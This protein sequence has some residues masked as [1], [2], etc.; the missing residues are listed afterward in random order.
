MKKIYLLALT[1]VL[2]L[3]S[4]HNFLKETPEDFLSAETD[5]VDANFVEAQ[6]QGAFKSMLWYRNDRAGLIGITGTDEAQGKTV[7]VN[8]WAEQGAL[9]KYNTTLNSDNWLTKWL[10]DTGYFGINR[11]NN[12]INSSRKQI[13]GV[14]DQWRKSIES[15]ARFVRAF[16]YF[17]LVQ[18]FG[19]VPLITEETK[20]STEPNYPRE[21]LDK[22][23]QFMIADLE[24]AI[25]NLATEYR[26]GRVTVGAARA[27][28]M[29]IYM[30]A[31]VESG[32]RDYAKAKEQFLAIEALGKYSLQPNYSELFHPDFE[33]GVES[34][35]EYQF[36]YPDEPN[37]F[38]YFVGSRAIGNYGHGA[39]FG[40]FLPTPYYLSLFVDP[41]TEQ[42]IDPSDERY[43]ASVRTE[44]RNYSTGEIITS[45]G[46]PE[47]LYPHCLKYEDFDRDSYC[48]N[49]AKNI[50]Y[51]RYADLILLYAEILNEEGNTS[52]AIEQINRVRARAKA[53]LLDQSLGKDEMLDYIYE[54][55]MR[56]LGMEG[57]RRFD[58]VRRGVDYFVSQVDRYNKFA[59]GNVKAFHA[60]YPVPSNEI[61]MNAG[62]S[63][64]DQN[65]GYN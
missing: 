23:Y 2:S 4:C 24:F 46:D 30:Y 6:L 35:Y 41:Q 27:M 52:G 59:K 44:F 31:P 32:V 61:N 12:T 9:D 33:N 21:S 17:N 36:E 37:H 56:E 40:V 15:E 29:K 8:Y 62:I 65:P 51:I 42:R 18:Y 60:L 14:S 3:S 11:S 53:T 10:W 26:A 48:W 39:G 55:R 13:E 58:L 7:E 38:Q 50:Y 34:V 19:R 47:Y 1:T 63:K 49:S 22:I 20:P 45:A 5:V 25:Q 57:W 16:D 54:E 64:E 28:L 43:A